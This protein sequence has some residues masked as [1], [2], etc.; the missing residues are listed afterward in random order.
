MKKL[1]LQQFT[2]PEKIKEGTKR[3]ILLGGSRQSKDKVRDATET[4][5][6]LKA[7]L[8]DI[9][10]QEKEGVIKKYGRLWKFNI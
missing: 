5:L 10:R 7:M 8:R 2:S 4:L 6:L 3:Q 1:S 9:K